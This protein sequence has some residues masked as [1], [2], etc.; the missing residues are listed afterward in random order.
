MVRHPMYTPVT[1]VQPV[2]KAENSKPCESFMYEVA[3]STDP[4]LDKTCVYYC[5]PNKGY[6]T[7]TFKCQYMDDMSMLI[8]RNN[9]VIATT[10]GYATSSPFA[11]TKYVSLQDADYK[12]VC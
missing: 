11:C 3:V 4:T 10:N 12:T 5:D 6:I 7:G 8:R 9:F 2:A 1:V